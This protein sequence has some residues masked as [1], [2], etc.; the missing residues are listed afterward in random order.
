M[1]VFIRP[2]A[3]TVDTLA[4]RKVPLLFPKDWEH[5][6]LTGRDYGTDMIIEIFK[7]GYATGN[8]LSL[9]IK[10]TTK[11]INEEKYIDFDVPVRTLIYS[12]MFIVPVLLVVCNV[13][14]DKYGFYY[15]WLQEYIKVVLNFEKPNW[16]KNKKTVRVKIPVNN[17][18]PGDEEKLEFIAD[19]PRR[20][21][22]W[23]QFA[24][25]IE[26]LRYRIDS[27]LSLENLFPEDF[28]CVEDYNEIEL[29]KNKDLQKIIQLITELIELK[30][31]FENKNW[32]SAQSVLKEFIIPA[33]NGATEL[34]S[35]SY[36]DR[37][38]SKEKL[39]KIFGASS[40]LGTNNDY[41]YFN[42]LWRL[43]DEYNF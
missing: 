34:Y 4:R 19:Y 6:E 25:I 12:E 29:K 15:L 11:K 39:L 1:S 14:E 27:F 9:Q 10:G 23:C 28:Q 40:F 3:H 22:D 38:Y 30:G 33:L 13:N 43:E 20:I 7:N 24:R 31:I 32:E 2:D 17:F 5:R 42:F 16:R 36:T 21:Y 37:L 26:D 18:M 8:S 35:K 41:S